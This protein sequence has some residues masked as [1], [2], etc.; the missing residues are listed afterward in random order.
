MVRNEFEIHRPLAKEYLHIRH[1]DGLEVEGDLQVLRDIGGD[2][3]DRQ[4]ATTEIDTNMQDL[5]EALRVQHLDR[6]EA[7]RYR[8]VGSRWK[9]RRRVRIEDEGRR[10]EA[11]VGGCGAP[12]STA[13]PSLPT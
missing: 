2:A 5:R 1:V 12:A 9:K 3:L 6:Q 8:R 13:P 7:G 11:R 10:G 4:R